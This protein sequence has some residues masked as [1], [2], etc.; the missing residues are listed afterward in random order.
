MKRTGESN[1][2]SASSHTLL[3]EPSKNDWKRTIEEK[4]GVPWNPF[5]G[6]KTHNILNYENYNGR[7]HILDDSNPELR[8]SMAEKIAIKNKSTEY[9]DPLA[10][11]TE[12]SLLSKV[13]FSEENVQ[14]LQNGLRAGVYEM[15]GKK[16]AIP[17]QNVDNLKIIMRSTF[18]QHAKHHQENI[19]QQVE[20]L[21]KYV[22]DYAVPSVYREAQGYLKYCEDQSTLVTPM[23]HPQQS[24]RDYKHLEWKGWL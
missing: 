7:V 12:E 10:G 2:P 20:V 6:A 24:D 5:L 8:F 21:N 15:S 16:L 13:Y 14:I 23:E 1:V 19:K 17:P 11:L 9:R 18:L 4:V 3:M 22:L